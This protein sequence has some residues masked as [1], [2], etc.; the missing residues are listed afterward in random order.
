MKIT[1]FLSLKKIINIF[2]SL[3]AC[4]FDCRSCC[5]PADRCVFFHQLYFIL[6]YYYSFFFILSQK[7]QTATT[8]GL[9]CICM[10][11]GWL[12]LLSRC[13]FYAPPPCLQ[14]SVPGREFFFYLIGTFMWC[15]LSAATPPRGFLVAHRT[16]LFLDVR[17]NDKLPPLTR[18]S[19]SC[20]LPPPPPQLPS[21]LFGHPTSG[22]M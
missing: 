11:K 15:P 10:A 5:C 14:G 4:W 7:L 1:E 3:C 20:S 6:Y 19:V 8:N 21:P 9:H 16:S 17:R 18:Q 13:F 2:Q 22:K 12:G